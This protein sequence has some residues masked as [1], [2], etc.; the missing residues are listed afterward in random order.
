MAA[1][2]PV[3]EEETNG[4][5]EEPLEKPVV[6]ASNGDIES[7]DRLTEKPKNH[8]RDKE[9][10]TRIENHVDDLVAKI[11]PNKQSLERRYAVFEYIKRLLIKCLGNR[12]CTVSMFGSV[13]LRTYLPDGDIDFTAIHPGSP[14][15]NWTEKLRE[16]L[17]AE[18]R[19]PNA[20]F[21]VRDVQTIHAEVKLMKCLVG[22][23]VVDISVN[24]LGG[25]STL[26]FLEEVDIYIGRS[27]LFKRSVILVKGWCYYESRLLGAHH[28]LISTYALETLVLYIFNVFHQT[29]NSPLKVLSVFLNFF[30]KF[31]W[32]KYCLSL[33]GPIPLAGLPSLKPEVPEAEGGLLFTDA[34]LEKLTHD[35]A[36]S[37]RYLPDSLVPSLPDTMTYNNSD[38]GQRP[39][40]TK[41]LNVLD[42]L[43]PTNNLGRS[44]SRSNLCRI[45][46]AFSHG[47]AKL[48]K[49][50]D[51][52]VE[53]GATDFQAVDAF[54]ENAA[55][56]GHLELEGRSGGA[57]S[58]SAGSSS[59]PGVSPSA[60]QSSVAASTESSSIS[61]AG[62]EEHG[63]GA[64]SASTPAAAGNER[65]LSGDAPAN[66]ETLVGHIR[67]VIPDSEISSGSALSNVAAPA[68]FPTL[69]PSPTSSDQESPRRQLDPEPEVPPRKTPLQVAELHAKATGVP[70]RDGGSSAS[71]AE[72]RERA[73]A[74][75]HTQV[76]SDS[77]GRE[78]ADQDEEGGEDLSR[79]G[80]SVGSPSRVSFLQGKFTITEEPDSTET[81]SGTESAAGGGSAPV[82]A[83]P[84]NGWGRAALEGARGKTAPE[85]AG[86]GGPR[87]WSDG[88]DGAV[89][90][91]R[92][93]S[94]PLSLAAGERVGGPGSLS[95]SSSAGE[96]SVQAM[97]ESAER[98]EQW[99]T[100]CF[101]L[102]REQTNMRAQGMLRPGSLMGHMPPNL[103]VHMDLH[104]HGSAVMSHVGIPPLIARS[105]P[106]AGP[107]AMHPPVPVPIPLSS[108]VRPPP[109]L[110]VHGGA[111]SVR[112][113]PRDGLSGAPPPPS[114]PPLPPG[115]PPGLP[116][117][118]QGD[119]LPPGPPHPIRAFL[120]SRLTPNASW[121]EQESAG[122]LTVDCEAEHAEG[123]GA[124]QVTLSAESEK[125]CATVLATRLMRAVFATCCCL[126][127]HPE[128]E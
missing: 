101:S 38:G 82:A 77:K 60:L 34:F 109:P 8:E 123:K 83:E 76:E 99:N 30:C 53:E 21:G 66:Q 32:D 104:L 10:M 48:Q 87:R 6:E 126:V 118:H 93:K 36:T 7:S 114:P 58:S 46:R 37:H 127:R 128:E 112:V 18:E 41:H 14:M 3:L 71:N 33:Q 95:R 69:H 44:V 9:A 24:Q 86:V 68:Q 42:P 105:S 85:S 61:D 16:A 111:P 124:L 89:A 43:L 92:G 2:P 15:H 102:A 51:K 84:A 81:G 40:L 113:S 96:R 88:G 1:A 31:D 94:S 63:G 35:Y 11:Q 78:G 120:S 65:S 57:S 115:M 125:D 74:E 55:A 106:P 23:I 67:V 26:C 70:G 107:P 110:Q 121:G 49:T 4:N 100:L 90:L 56:E 59:G 22:D 116:R 98:A 117:P 13:P 50:L 80:I 20:E 29:L 122:N 28:G 91:L 45:R 103:D 119:P 12:E 97:R 39:L 108:Q 52:T 25:L 64:G 75:T 62:N 72:N 27:N 47:A 17:D 19:N 5:L 79:V 54:F 73:E